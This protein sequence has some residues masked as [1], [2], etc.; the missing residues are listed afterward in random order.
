M[1]NADIGTFR[2]LISQVKQMEIGEVN[3]TPETRFGA[4]LGMKSLELVGLVFMCEQTFGVSLVSRPGLLVKLQ[5]VGEAVETIRL[6]QCG[7]W[8]DPVEGEFETAASLQ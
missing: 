4:D 3:V 7:L 1:N 5:T 6:M 8:V 2:R